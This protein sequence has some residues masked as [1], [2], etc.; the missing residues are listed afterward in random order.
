MLLA[1][2]Q[3]KKEKPKNGEDEAD[4]TE[5]DQA[6]E[7]SDFVI[8]NGVLTGLNNYD[9]VEAEI[10]ADVRDIGKGAL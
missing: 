4:E 1:T 2:K 5:E 10:P 7:I 9:I 8:E 3:K 6:E